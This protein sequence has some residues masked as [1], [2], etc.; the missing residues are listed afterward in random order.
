MVQSSRSI[1]REGKERIK[2]ELKLFTGYYLPEL[3]YGFFDRLIGRDMKLT[4]LT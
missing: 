1:S 2:G 4:L 3:S